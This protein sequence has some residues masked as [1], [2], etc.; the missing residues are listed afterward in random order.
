MQE[1]LQELFWVEIMKHKLLSGKKE[2][3]GQQNSC[4]VIQMQRKPLDTP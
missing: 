3:Q 4:S 1:N 2:A